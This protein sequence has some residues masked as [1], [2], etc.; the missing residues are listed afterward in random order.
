M[1]LGALAVIWL[2]G[3]LCHDELQFLRSGMLWTGPQR[4]EEEGTEGC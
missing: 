3:A 1:L 2:E 4:V